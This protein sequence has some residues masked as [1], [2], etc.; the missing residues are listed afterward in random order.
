M[1]PSTI[2]SIIDDL[3]KAA[4]GVLPVSVSPPPVAP[5]PSAP[6][7]AG[8]DN[9]TVALLAGV[10]AAALGVIKL[11]TLV[12]AGLGYYVLVVKK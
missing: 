5:A 4:P 10:T 8:M 3:N 11:S 2:D 1:G 9:E 12:L 6:L 7:V